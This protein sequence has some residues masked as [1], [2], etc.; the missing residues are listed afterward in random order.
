MR[1]MMRWAGL[2]SLLLTTSAVFAQEQP[3]VTV[4][5]SGIANALIQSLAEANDGSQV[6]FDAEGTA[7]GIDRFCNGDID[8]ATAARQ[9]T[10]AEAA[11]CGA[12]AVAYSEF[13]A[14]HRIVAFI[15]QAGAGAECLAESQ[16][17]AIF[18]PSASAETIDWSFISEGEGE[19]APLIV[20][21]APADDQ[22][23]LA[24]IDG[25]VP[26]D[27]LRRDARHYADVQMA[28]E[29]VGQTEGALGFVAWQ[30]ALEPSEAVRLLQ[31][32]AGDAGECVS[33]SAENVEQDKYSA[34]MSLYLY[35][36]RARLAENQ[37]IHDLMRTII[38][39]ANAPL[40][41]AMA[42]APP[43]AATYRLNADIL[44]DAIAAD[45]VSGESTF[46]MPATLSG[47]LNIVGAANAFEA[48]DPVAN[49]LTQT[50]Q[51]LEIELGLTGRA[52][53]LAAFCAGEADIAL[54]DG[55][56]TEAELAPCLEA[57]VTT[58]S[59]R[60][61]AQAAVLIGN[62]ADEHTRCL[63]AEQVNAVWRAES[64]ETVTAW[65][66]VDS[67]FPDQSMTLFG[68]SLLDLTSD[69]LLQTAGPVIPPIRRDTEKDYDPLYRAAA[70]GNAPG[71]LTY[72]DWRDYQRVL[73]NGQ[74]NIRLTAVDA[75][76]GCVAPSPATIADGSYALSRPATLLVSQQA[77]AAPQCPSLSLVAI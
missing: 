52:T 1:F 77:L 3:P 67:A 47:S 72:M 64:A 45:S 63:T 5:G 20:P 70:V 44:A 58:H 28:L 37:Q 25:I 66:G 16:L 62:A 68:L 10:G 41:E 60:L 38:D 76:A 73:E 51:D 26:G 71:A 23:A 12:N 40:I 74:A 29:L 4:I 43:T 7:A 22:I 53:G 30:A 55:E 57:G 48:L 32:S 19:E 2:L 54:L 14:G 31:Y 42:A 21:V 36:N 46:A 6:A 65:S 24:I 56:A 27:G 49:S 11:I 8:I 35:V 34:A 50:H 13:L 61:G 75:G 39:E 15:A 59:T 33:P 17:Q 69:I 18:K 9:M